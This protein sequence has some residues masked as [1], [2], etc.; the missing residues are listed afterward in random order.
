MDSYKALIVYHSTPLQND[1]SPS[2]LL[3]NR[4]LRTPLPIIESQL[5]SCVPDYSV[6]QHKEAQYK[7]T[8]RKIFNTCHHASP[9]EPLDLG[10]S[11]GITG[12]G[13]SGVVIQPAETP[14][15]SVV[16]TST[17]CIRRDCQYLTKVPEL[18]SD[19]DNTIDTRTKSSTTFTNQNSNH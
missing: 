9:L 16:L 11:V 8:S 3:M 19:P 5:V 12:R 4:K 14:R 7:T 2:E 6:I 15:S 1:Y 13:D 18:H 10:Q 17:G